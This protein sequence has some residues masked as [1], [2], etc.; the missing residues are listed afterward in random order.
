MAPQSELRQRQGAA[1]A[2]A[3][4]EDK[5]T[6]TWQEVAKNNHAGS[7]WMIVRNKVYDVTAW[8]DKHPGG[9]EMVL[10][11][12]GRECTD[13]FDSYHPFSDKAEQVLAKYE[14]GTLTGPSEFPVY[15]PDSGFYK[16]CRKRV[17]EYFE[18]NKLNPQD[19]FAGFWRMIVVVSVAAVA[20]YGM[21]FSNIFAVQAIAAVVFGFCQAL[22]LLHV[23]HDS[24]H[25]AFTKQPFIR[26][27]A[28]RLFMDW[29]AGA[30]MVS[31]LNQHVVGH[32]IYT[33]VT[34][35]DPD[36][37][38]NLEGDIRRLVTRQVLLPMYRFQHIYLPPLYGLLGLKFRIQDFTDTFG[39]LTNGPIRVNPPSTSQWVQLILSKSFWVFYR[40]YLPLAVFQMPVKT[41]LY[42]FLIAELFTGWHL[43]FNFQVSHVS[44]ECT[45]PNGNEVKTNLD[46][47]WAVSQVKSSLD[48][49]HGS[50]FTT[51]MA[52]ALNYQVTHHLF[53][54]V[55]QYHYPAIAPIIMQVCKEYKINYP[56]L[57]TFTAAFSA[58][59]NHLKEMGRQGVFV[60][61][62]MG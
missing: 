58:H 43:A 26:E 16:E 23:M 52:G 12:A 48:Y 31:W 53:P 47:E 54:T 61:V 39:T 29:F 49:S 11:H 1:G 60:S 44:T 46:D 6:F 27:F 51:F 24:S 34:G 35:A 19:G 42:V 17:G 20:Y 18:K 10:L 22:P 41:F 57:P 4:K 32:H 8:V 55:S 30:S 7:A 21:H 5:K 40:I 2:G 28:G 37:P 56:I 14:I 50:W 3:S 59:M 15:K 25:A 36:L 9:R 45:Y 13:T 62:H 33:N 38:V